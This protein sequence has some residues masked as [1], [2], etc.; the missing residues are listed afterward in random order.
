MEVGAAIVGLIVAGAQISAVL[1]RFISGCTNAPAAAHSIYQ[2]VNEFS[3]VLQKL[4]H[5]VF[6]PEPL[7]NAKASLIDTGAISSTL[8]QC[9]CTFSELEA[10]LKRIKLY[11]LNLEGKKLGVWNRMKWNFV[12]QTMSAMI[13]RIQNHKSTVAILVSLLNTYVSILSFLLWG[14][15]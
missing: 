10:E 15:Y 2:E 13:L 4:Q 11:E 8:I 1:H 6:S 7:D 3:I 9:V 12:E 5:V 14:R